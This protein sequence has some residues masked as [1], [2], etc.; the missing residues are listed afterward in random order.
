MQKRKLLFVAEELALNGAMNSLIALLRALPRENYD[1]SLFLFDH[2]GEMMD[3]LPKDIHLLPEIIEYSVHRLPAKQAIY[4]AIKNNR[5]DL[6]FYRLLVSFQRRV[7]CAYKLW[8]WLPE[9]TSY[10]DVVIS[11]SDGFAAPMINKKVKYGKKC[12]WVHFPY[13]NVPLHSYEYDALKKA[14]ACAVVSYTVGKELEA[15]LESK[16]ENMYVIHNII[17]AELCITKATENCEIPIRE[18]VKRIVSVGR[19]TPAKGFD[20]ICSIATILLEKGINFE[21]YILGNGEDLEKLRLQ[22]VDMNVEQCVHFI[23]NKDNPMPWMKLS[24]VIVQPSIFESWGMTVSEALCLG[25]AVVTSDLP[26][27]KEQIS[28]GLNGLISPLEPQAMA[29]AIYKILSD[30]EFKH[31]LENN[32]SSYPFTQERVILEFNI[33]IRDILGSNN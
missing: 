21:W 27:F 11:Y 12:C 9:I 2:S 20:M 3:K 13:T 30:E 23:G 22:A 33:M 4:K 18:G 28:D 5:I 31:F 24:D 19:L 10:Y 25:K 1:I 14:D 6:F 16:L 29:E 26:V 8:R 32:A 7:S 17:N 15:V